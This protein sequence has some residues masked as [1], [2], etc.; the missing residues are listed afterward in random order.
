[1]SL[2]GQAGNV[3]RVTSPNGRWLAFTYDT[4][5]PMNHVTQVTDNI[6]RTV[7]YTYTT[8]GCLAT[9]T[10]PLNNVTTY[11]YDT[12]NRMLTITDG[13]WDWIIGAQTLAPM[14]ANPSPAPAVHCSN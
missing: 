12:S 2:S 10:D 4:H 11:T 8:A 7:G 6:G 5:T 9:V 13:R 3:T 1:M 14:P